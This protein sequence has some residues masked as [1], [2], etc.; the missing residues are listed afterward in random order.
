MRHSHSLTYIVSFC[1]FWLLIGH[2]WILCQLLGNKYVKGMRNMCFM[3]TSK[4]FLLSFLM[5]TKV[6]CRYIGFCRHMFCVK[7]ENLVEWLTVDLI[8]SLDSFQMCS[9]SLNNE[10]FVTN[11]TLNHF[12]HSK[13]SVSV[14]VAYTHITIGA[15]TESLT[16]SLTAWFAQSVIH[17]AGLWMFYKF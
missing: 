10:C 4:Y 15:A 14:L 7:L 5:K 6:K 12:H 8:Y 11:P 16:H 2:M 3:L 9:S 1:G 13:I 17:V